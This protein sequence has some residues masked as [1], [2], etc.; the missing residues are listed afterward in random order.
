MRF[1]PTS[2]LPHHPGVGVG[3][4]MLLS[5]RSSSV[6]SASTAKA[7]LWLALFPTT[8]ELIM[9]DDDF[10]IGV[11]H[12]LG[13]PLMDGL[14]PKCFCDAALKDDPQQFLSAHSSSVGR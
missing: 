5:L 4:M 14:P 6:A 12:R 11:K 2:R 9:A 3:F 1:P 8:P 7:S 13:V 10:V